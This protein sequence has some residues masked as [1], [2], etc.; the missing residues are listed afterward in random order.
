MD[1][2]KKIKTNKP[3]WKTIKDDRV[4]HVWKCLSCDE[5]AHVTPTFYEESGTPVCSGELSHKDRGCDGDD[6]TY[7]KT[8]IR[9]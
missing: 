6:M 3:K 5:E 9:V 2:K 8:M 4:I 1:T 7:V